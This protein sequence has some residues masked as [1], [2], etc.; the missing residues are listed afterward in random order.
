MVHQNDIKTNIVNEIKIKTVKLTVPLF[1]W[2][3]IDMGSYG[4]WVFRN[5]IYSNHFT[6]NLKLFPTELIA[7]NASYLKAETTPFLFKL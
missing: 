7:A 5:T 2:P 3:T 6:C 1:T 4:L